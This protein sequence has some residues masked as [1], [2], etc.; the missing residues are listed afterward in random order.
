MSKVRILSI[1]EFDGNEKLVNFYCNDLREHLETHSKNITAPHKHNFFLTVL[2]TKGSGTHEID[3]EKYDVSPGSV[4]MLNPGQA[5]NWELSDD[6][7]G[8]IFF[9]SQ[10]FYEISF[11]EQ[12]IY[13]FPFFYPVRNPSML[14]LKEGE[15]SEVSNAFNLILKEYRNRDVW[16]IKKIVSLLNCIYIDISRVYLNPVNANLVKMDAYSAYLRE[17][18]Q[19]IEEN[20]K[21]EKSPSA[22]ADLLNITIRHLNRLTQETLGKST[23]QLITERVILEAKR[24]IVYDSTSLAKISY[25]LGY[26]DYA[27][28]SRLFKKWTK[29]TPSEFSALYKR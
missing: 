29:L 23:T 15:L 18:E 5:H 12:S 21:Q 9:H 8:I 25:E 27:Y 26:D 13:D 11:T 6:I 14:T 28:F 19:L 22:Y 3:F 24:L 1:S 17:L 2:F 16:S 20:F 4:F 10:E 7:E